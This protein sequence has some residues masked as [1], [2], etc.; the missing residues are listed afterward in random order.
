M[1]HKLYILLIVFIL[2]FVLVSCVGCDKEDVVSMTEFEESVVGEW[3]IGS[4]KHLNFV[5]NYGGVGGYYDVLTYPS[6][7]EFF[8]DFCEDYIENL[9]IVFL[10]ERHDKL[11]QDYKGFIQFKERKEEFSWKQRGEAY[12]IS[13]SRYIEL[14]ICDGKTI[15]R[16]NTRSALLN[17]SGDMLIG[18]KSAEMIYTFNKT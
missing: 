7:N 5:E 16:A 1:R 12:V 9:R 4:V 3:K 18:L 11:L 17:A 13:F 6:S 10:N 15:S 2:F 14:D 8:N